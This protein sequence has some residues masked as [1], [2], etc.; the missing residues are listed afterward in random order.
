M[1]GLVRAVRE[2]PRALILGITIAV[3]MAGVFVPIVFALHRSRDSWS[4]ASDP[5]SGV[6]LVANA[7]VIALFVAAR[8]G[9]RMEDE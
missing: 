8:R 6:A 1:N 7:L 9:R 3:V 4:V 5:L 2:A